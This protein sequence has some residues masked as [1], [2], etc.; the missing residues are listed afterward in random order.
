MNIKHLS[1]IFIILWGFSSKCQSIEN[2]QY[3]ESFIEKLKA[4]QEVSQ[5][6]FIGDSHTQA[7][8][9]TGYLRSKFQKKYGNAGRGLIFPHSLANSNGDL[10]FVATSNQTWETFRLV[11]KQNIFSEFGIMGFLIGNVKDSFLQIK[12]L[13][14]EDYFDKV[15][16]YHSS[17]MQG[18]NLS[19]YQPNIDLENFTQRKN[20]IISHEIKDNQTFHELASKF[21]T[22]TTKLISLN[23][24]SVQT[25]KIGNIINI[26]KTTIEYKN[27]FEN[28]AQIH[29]ETN[30][31]KDKTEII[32]P[33]KLQKLLIRANSKNGNIFY[34]FQFAKN[35]KNGVIFHSIGVNGATY[36]DY[37]KHALQT[38]QI[39]DIQ[40]DIAIIALGTNEAMTNIS[41]KE[42]SN[43]AKNLIQALRTNNP[44]LPI[45]LISPT[46]NKLRPKK[47]EKIDS[48]IK[49]IASENH[50]A[51]YSLYQAMGREGYFQKA[52]QNKE[53]DK[54]GVHFLKK[55]Y[56]KQA[57]KI[58]NTFVQTLE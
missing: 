32:F 49:K 46:D 44:N 48:W 16:I 30:F 33:K 15:I 10:D 2:K 52:L 38:K 6:L 18:E 53:A 26:E 23:G 12:F 19:V 14:E 31:Q 28:L 3:L 9:I 34:G 36:F 50:T 45:L 25:P 29:K 35:V 51:F 57:E 27:E 4:N 47:I 40:S 43:N 21:Y 13:N 17:I 41:E 42:F 58:W 56:E 39:Q 1:L 22:T 11:H 55:G 7:D 24:Q 20:E 8:Y 54:D 37:T 5:I